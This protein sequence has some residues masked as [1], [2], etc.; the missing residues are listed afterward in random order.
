[1][2]GRS[3]PRLLGGLLAVLLP[4]VL[5][6]G[7]TGPTGTPEL[8]IGPARASVP[9]AGVAQLVLEIENV[10]DGDDRLVAA[11]T[12]RALAVELHETAIDDEGRATMT[13]R[14]D[15]VALPAGTTTR[16]RPGGLHLMLVVPDAT[17][18]LGATFDVTLSFDRSPPS[19]LAVTVVPTV[20]L[21][22]DTAGP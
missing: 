1:M 4:L 5:V 22:D 13:L 9:A 21:L 14:E 11:T 6:A 8:R 3:H 16:F 12:D 10:G 2:T 18:V 17:I 19:T 20:E 15:G 7:C